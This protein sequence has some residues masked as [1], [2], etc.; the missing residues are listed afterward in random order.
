[1][2][3]GKGKEWKM[4]SVITEP[5]AVNPLMAK[6][7]SSSS[8]GLVPQVRWSLLTPVHQ[9]VLSVFHVGWT[10][11]FQPVALMTAEF[12]TAVAV[13]SGIITQRTHSRACRR[14]STPIVTK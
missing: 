4:D 6:P 10:G 5:S 2:R 12:S 8:S 14:K 9:A 7:D 3:D 13:L 1:M 11:Y